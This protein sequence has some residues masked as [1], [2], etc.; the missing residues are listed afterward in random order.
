MSTN[1]SQFIIGW[2][3]AILVI[4]LGSYIIITK[5]DKKEYHYLSCFSGGQ[6]VVNA[7][8]ETTMRGYKLESGELLSP[9]GL[10]CVLVTTSKPLEQPKPKPVNASDVQTQPHNQESSSPK[11]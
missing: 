9:D 7:K 10:E 1:K 2:L 11:N 8:V 3:L 6:Q 5:T 4:G